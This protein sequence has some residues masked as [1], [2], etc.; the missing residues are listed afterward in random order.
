MG[1][2]KN[3]AKSTEKSIVKPTVI[4]DPACKLPPCIIY[5]F[6]DLFIEPTKLLSQW[7]HYFGITISVRVA[8][9][10]YDDRIN[11][12]PDVQV[13]NKNNGEVPHHVREAIIN[14]LEHGCDEIRKLNKLIIMEAVVAPKTMLDEILSGIIAKA[15]ANGHS[16]TQPFRY[17]Q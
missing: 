8:D 1:E 3:R 9:G 10:P 7:K 5:T 15:Q 11:R 14:A 16:V 2:A 12:Y 17:A 4:V 13:F 6:S